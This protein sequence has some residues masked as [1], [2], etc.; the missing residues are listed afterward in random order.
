L[1]SYKIAGL[2]NFARYPTISD[3]GSGLVAV[4]TS[5]FLYVLDGNT[6]STVFKSQAFTE[7][8]GYRG[9][10]YVWTGL[11]GKR[12]LVFFQGTKFMTYAV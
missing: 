10:P 9:N 6:G 8:W 11:D 2:D 1:H 12:H 7:I 3:L 5:D 4:V